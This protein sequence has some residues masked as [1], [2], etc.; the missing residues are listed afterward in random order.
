MPREQGWEDDDVLQ[1]PIS[2]DGTPDGTFRCSQ[3]Q[4]SLSRPL[5]LHLTFVSPP[6]NPSTPNPQTNSSPCISL[7]VSSP[8]M[9]PSSPPQN[10]PLPPHPQSTCATT[11]LPPCR[12]TNALHPPQVTQQP[13]R[14]SHVPL[15][16]HSRTAHASCMTV[17]TRPRTDMHSPL[18]RCRCLRVARGMPDWE[19]R[20]FV[21]CV[22]VSGRHV[23]EMGRDWARW[24]LVG[25]PIFLFLRFLGLDACAE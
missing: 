8:S 24:L 6:Y 3:R 25:G 13:T 20:G 22:T 18:R 5:S 15:S 17:Q 9:S 4:L 12:T 14:P 21:C 7:A 19:R 16:A 23:G 1:I 10:P 2:P 11:S